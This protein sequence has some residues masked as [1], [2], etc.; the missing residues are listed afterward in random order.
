MGRQAED[1]TPG[2]PTAAKPTYVQRVGNDL[3]EKFTNRELEVLGLLAGR[4]S[5][6]EIAYE[7][8]LSPLTVRK[9]ISNIFDKL[10]VHKRREAVTR[11][12]ELGLLIDDQLQ[13]QS[14]R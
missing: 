6:K 10:H 11:A 12:R 7:L 14:S 4:L 3:L 1:N 8:T 9:H 5:T 13:L 2:M